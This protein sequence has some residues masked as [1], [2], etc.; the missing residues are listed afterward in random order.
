M[1][2][3]TSGVQQRLIRQESFVQPEVNPFVHPKRIPLKRKLQMAV[4]SVTVAPVRMILFTLT[5]LLTYLCAIPLTW[6]VQLKSSA[7]VGKLRYAMFEILRLLG[8]LSFFFCGFHHV[9]VRG[10]HAS[11]REA[12]M[13][14]MAPHSSFFDGIAVFIDAGLPS[15]VSRSENAESRL[16]GTLLRATQP[17]LVS[18]DDPDSRQNTI[19][20]IVRRAR[21]DEDW[22]QILVFP[23]GTCSN[24]RALITFK[25]GA[26]I[27]AAPVQP[28]TIEYLNEWDTYRWTMDGPGGLEL[29]WMTF[30]QWETRCRVTFMPV[31]RPSDEELTDPK[32]FA[33]GVRDAMAHQLGV[34]FTEHTF[35][36]CRLMRHASLLKLPM[37][38]GLIEFAKLSRKLDIDVERAKELLS[39]YSHIVAENPSGEMTIDDLAAFLSLPVTPMLCDMFRLY[40]RDRSGKI[41]FREYVIG[42]SLLA[43]PAVTAVTVRAAFRAFDRDRDGV[44]GRREFC[45]LLELTQTTGLEQAERIF[46]EI[47]PRDRITFDEFHAFAKR[48]PEY[49]YLFLSY[50]DAYEAEKTFVP[51]DRDANTEDDS[52]ADGASAT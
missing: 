11:R 18:R 45:E 33:R 40:D 2:E 27:P 51:D 8:R 12:P 34:P 31:Y 5:V 10:R 24:G 17:V 38:T 15:A 46:G 32:Q 36:D 16:L 13:L 14:V 9:E 30:C 44:I 7:P 47:T 26:F 3:D 25:S 19:R 48:R 4:M 52:Q 42:L 37:E 29:L 41:D 50:K 6:G 23:E 43:T 20:E 1:A 28:V 49:A 35:E 21:S 22:P 39:G